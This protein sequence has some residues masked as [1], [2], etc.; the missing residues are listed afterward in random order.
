MFS[1]P[2][3]R[4]PDPT[5]QYARDR[6]GKHPEPAAVGNHLPRDRPHDGTQ[7]EGKDTRP[8]LDEQVREAA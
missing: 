2:R 4:G 3:V 6:T 8:P 7:E 1:G 5:H